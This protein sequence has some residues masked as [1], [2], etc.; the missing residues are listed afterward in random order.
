MAGIIQAVPK[1]TVDFA[2]L[3]VGATQDIVLADEV[4]LPLNLEMSLGVR[5]HNHT[6]TSSAG[7]I[8]I[9]AVP[10]LWTPE[11]PGLALV[12]TVPAGPPV[13]INGNTP[14]STYCPRFLR[15]VGSNCVGPMTRVVARGSRTAAGALSATVSVDITAKAGTTF[16][17]THLP[18]C[19][20]WIHAD[21]YDPITGAWPDRTGLGNDGAQTVVGRRPTLETATF[22]GLRSVQFDGVTQQIDLNGAVAT[23]LGGTA[24]PYSAIFLAEI[25][26]LPSSAGTFW[27]ATHV[28]SSSPE[29]LSQ[30]QADL[31]GLY[32]R[33]NDSGTL[34]TAVSG[35]YSG[36]LSSI[37][38]RFDGAAIT[39]V[40]NGTT[41]VT[42]NI[43]TDPL[44]LNQ[45]TVGAQVV[46]GTPS[47]WLNMRLREFAMYN[48]YHGDGSVGLVVNGMR[49]RA[50]MTP[51]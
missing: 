25:V 49:E 21:E 35:I 46:V 20:S 26:N 41:Y 44:T 4:N 15:T 9:M 12:S 19:I 11:D 5:V 23:A 33:R 40:I 36:G 18:N 1:R 32:S 45:F 37:S 29:I 13:V 22:N 6:L 34:R 7:T 30:V 28:S 14:S 24:I 38:Q 51:L 17:P 8:S 43:S 16:L 3:A 27:S 2:T 10:Q 42:G 47:N 48:T 50:G 39:T 31:S